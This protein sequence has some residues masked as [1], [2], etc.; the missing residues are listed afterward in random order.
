VIVKF[1]THFHFSI[2]AM[3]TAIPSDARFIQPTGL[4]LA[5]LIVSCVI[6]VLSVVGVSAR[7]YTRIVTRALGVDDAFIIFGTV[8]ISPDRHA[9]RHLTSVISY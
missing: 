6:W 7:T 2:V 4:P 8:S 9:Y 5:I 3:S 1:P